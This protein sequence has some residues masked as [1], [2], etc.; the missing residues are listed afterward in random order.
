MTTAT[1]TVKNLLIQEV[2]PLKTGERNG[3][4]WTLYGVTA[5]DAGGEALVLTTF[6]AKWQKL[7]GQRV[8]ISYDTQVKTLGDGREVRDYR[9]VEP[10]TETKPDR[11]G[12]MAGD[13]AGT[14]T[15]IR[16][17]LREIR[18]IEMVLLETVKSRSRPGGGTA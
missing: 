4:P 1:L 16:N 7:T 14:L 8:P 10:K 3:R 11:S 12:A 5:I 9:I 6:E 2:V 15:E 13:P 18:D 17:L